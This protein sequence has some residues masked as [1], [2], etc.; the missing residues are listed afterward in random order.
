M[1]HYLPLFPL[2]L[3]AFPGEDV[4]LHIFEERYKQLIRDCIEKDHAF[5]IPAYINKKIEY[6]TEVYVKKIVKE[7]EDGRMDITT[8]ASRA[9]KVMSYMNPVGGKLYAGGDVFYLK[10]KMDGTEELRREMIK[11]ITKLYE[12]MNI[13]KR[14]E[15]DADITTF[16]IGH[17]VGL[18]LEQEYQ[19]LKIEREYDRQ[20][21]LVQHLKKTIP[22]L[23]EM[24]RTKERIRM[25]GHFKHFDPLDF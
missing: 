8:K 2:N 22:V 16:E 25:N 12:L 6:G 4:N 14:V 21:F 7:Y 17:K 3:V 11:L 23:Q 20:L 5:G 1:D 10:D 15:V 19:L 18:S 13:V 24:E 9:F